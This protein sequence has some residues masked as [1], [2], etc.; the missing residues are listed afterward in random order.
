MPPKGEKLTAQQIADFTQWVKM[1]APDPR[2]GSAEIESKLSGLTDKARQHWAYQPV[3][4]PAPPAV[5]NQ[6]W[7]RSPV[8]AFIL[9]KLEGA[10]MI[11]APDAEKETLLRRATYDLIGLPPTPREVAAF[12]AD[13]SPTAF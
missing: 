2:V 1:G 4:N 10:N 13:K 6:G 9:A 8:D 7:P 11:P 12:L 5:K 3:K